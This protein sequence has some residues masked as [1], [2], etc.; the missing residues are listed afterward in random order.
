[1]SIQCMRI[2]RW[3]PKATNT[4]LQYVTLIVFP[5]QQWL[6]QSV[7]MLYYTLHGL[8]CS[9]YCILFKIEFQNPM[10]VLILRITG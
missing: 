7:S 8:S 4:Y 2:S 5:L 6:H 1:M 9:L 3:V 10:Q